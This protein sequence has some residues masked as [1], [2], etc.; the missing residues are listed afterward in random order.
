MTTKQQHLSLA[1]TKGFV[2]QTSGKKKKIAK[3]ELNRLCFSLSVCVIV[4]FDHIISLQNREKLLSNC[5]ECVRTC[6]SFYCNLLYIFISLL[7]HSFFFKYQ[8]LQMMNKRIHVWLSDRSYE[9]S[10]SFTIGISSMLKERV[11]S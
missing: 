6:V 7:L 5:Y 4:Y 2:H 11:K 1:N 3:Y 9:S 10:V 8:Q